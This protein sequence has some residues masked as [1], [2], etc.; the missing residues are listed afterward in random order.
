MS[1]VVIHGPCCLYTKRVASE[2]LCCDE[3]DIYGI[4]SA[5]MVLPVMGGSERTGA[6]LSTTWLEQ[7]RVPPVE[8]SEVEKD[9]G[10]SK[11]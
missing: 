6:L 11:T 7:N 9:I 4:M 2:Q 5:S 8:R 3:T 10:T 1:Y